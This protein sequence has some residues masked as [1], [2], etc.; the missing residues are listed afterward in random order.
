VSDETQKMGIFDA[1]GWV[2]KEAEKMGAHVTAEQALLMV[3][4]KWSE[5][6]RG[7]AS[8]RDT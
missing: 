3:L 5:D 4:N 1:V 6:K 8:K 7:E 2:Q